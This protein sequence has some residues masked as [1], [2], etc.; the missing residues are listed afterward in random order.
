MFV[1][2]LPAVIVLA[3]L[4]LVSST[5]GAVASRLITGKDIKDSSVTSADIKDRSLSTKDFSKAAKGKLT[6]ATGQTGPAG[7]R[8][9]AGPTGASGP[10]GPAGPAGATGPAG[11][12]GGTLPG[13]V[14]T[15]TVTYDGSGA[16][17]EGGSWRIPTP[18]APTLPGNTRVTP[19]DIRTTGDISACRSS[20]NFNFNATAVGSSET[21]RGLGTESIPGPDALPHWTREQFGEMAVFPGAA[22]RTLGL[23]VNCY[24]TVGWDPAPPPPFTS[25]VTL[26][27]EKLPSS[28][29]R[30]LQG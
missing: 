24:A 2:P 5:G 25:T 19:V 11:P 1:R 21:E 10:V 7:E 8:G 3:A 15:W 17:E 29:A 14:V 9:P 4:A 23:F 6:G 13:E 12:A 30:A 27:V 28:P 20:A 22:R 16:T 26:H 18:N